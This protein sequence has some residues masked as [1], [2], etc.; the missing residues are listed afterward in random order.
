MARRCDD[1]LTNDTMTRR[2]DSSSS[3]EGEDA[4]RVILN[5]IDSKGNKTESPPNGTTE[6]VNFVSF[7]TLYYG[8]SEKER[9]V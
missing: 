3:E 4:I 6:A 1:F 9:E 7:P 2:D 5:S 8:S